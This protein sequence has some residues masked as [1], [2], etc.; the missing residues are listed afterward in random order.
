MQ[1]IKVSIINRENRKYW[2][3]MYYVYFENSVVKKF[4]ESTKVLKTEKTLKYM[5]TQYLSP[6]IARKQEE[7]NIKTNVSKKFS[8]F[9]EKYLKLHEE[10]KSFH[11]RI[12]VY[13]KVNDFFKDFDINK[14]TRL[15]VKEYLSS[16]DNIKDRT[17]KDY[18]S[19]IKSVI[20]IA[21][22]AEI[23]NKNVA[24]D[25]TFKASEKELIHPFST[26]EVSLLL[27]KSH[28]MFRNYLGI[29]LHTGMRSGEIL[30]LMHQDILNDRI[31]I[32]RS[33][34]KG[35][36]TTPKTIG[37]IRDIPMFEAVKPFIESQGKLS[38]SLYLF[39][40][41][42][43]FIK[44]ASFFKRRWHQLV[45][46]C[47]IEYR[48]LYSTRHTFIT[49]MLNSGK[50]KIMEIAAIVGHTSPEMIIKNYAGFIKDS[51]LKVD[52]SIDLFKNVSDTFSDT[53]KIKI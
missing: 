42:G 3:V 6:W 51:H 44:D 22:D 52:T 32:K 11:N 40:H 48:K 17:K 30:G 28:G 26:D 10:D 43:V 53:L 7:L 14:I 24:T 29:A 15:M 34:S 18:L 2:Y 5:Q 1:N 39:E 33:I 36:I 27:E 25:I 45:E 38:K 20:D 19:C 46:D 12:Y 21:M 50:F 4:E 8:Y 37:S 47:G 13:R 35:R 16:F 23:V 9:Y 31:T 49:A 41:D